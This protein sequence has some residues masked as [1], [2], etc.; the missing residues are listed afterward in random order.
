MGDSFL[1]YYDIVEFV[2]KTQFLPKK[3]VSNFKYVDFS[4]YKNPL[5][6]K[7]PSI[8]GF[9]LYLQKVR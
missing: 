8:R 6:I 7:E 3:I 2:R 5:I 1:W 9:F 4:M